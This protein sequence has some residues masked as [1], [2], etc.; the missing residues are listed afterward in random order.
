MMRN[1]IHNGSSDSVVFMVAR[2]LF[3]FSFFVSFAVVVVPFYDDM[4]M[5][6]CVCKCVRVR[7]WST[8]DDKDSKNLLKRV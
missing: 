7:A 1:S 2:Y 3:L 4:R 6:V 8:T 5:S